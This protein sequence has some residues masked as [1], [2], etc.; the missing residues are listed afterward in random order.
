MA[1]YMN[2]QQ[3]ICQNCQKQFKTSRSLHLHL[4]AHDLNPQEYYHK[5]FPR[6]DLQDH[7][8]INFKDVDH[9]FN[10]DF[11]SKTN[12]KKY[13][14]GLN[15]KQKVEYFE[16]FI[17]KRKKEKELNYALCQVETRS[18][19]CPPL[20]TMIDFIPDYDSENIKLQLKP[21][22]K[23]NLDLKN[24]KDLKNST[25]Y[26]DTR[27]QKPFRFHCP[28]EL[29]HLTFGDYALN[30]FQHS[31]NIRIERKSLVDFIGTM[32]GGYE[33]FNN[34][35]KNAKKDNAYLVILVTTL[36]SKALA[37]DYIPFLKDKIKA[38]PSFI[39]HRVRDLLQ[40]NDNIQFLFVKGRKD[41]VKTIETIFSLG[42]VCKSV[43]LQYLYDKKKLSV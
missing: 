37:F 30:D 42:S 8:L 15:N 28:F 4:K 21:R 19:E 25:I 13:F 38:T 10:T 22:F 32:S 39:F 29:K 7:T 34:E 23:Y 12:L 27:E 16:K 2:E 40:E 43:D 14:K 6:Y 31:G 41:A 36:M 3:L 26:I 5:Y 9:Y 35:I 18:L 20:S 1:K 24:K 11:N 33:R 17:E